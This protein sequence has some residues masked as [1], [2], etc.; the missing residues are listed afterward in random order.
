MITKI[1]K[2]HII[3]IGLT[4]VCF[5]CKILK[6]KKKCDCPEWSKTF[7]KKINPNIKTLQYEKE[8]NYC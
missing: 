8:S 1:F 3:I 4:L 6:K 7:Q 5:S 2:Y